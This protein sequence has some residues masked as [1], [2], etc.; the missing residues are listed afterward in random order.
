MVRGL[1]AELAH[2]T[3]TNAGWEA[4][5]SPFGD[6]LIDDATTPHAWWAAEYVTL[7]RNM[8]V[9]EQG[10]D[11][12]LMSALSPSWLT[13]G[14]RI[15]VRA[16]PTTR[17]RVSFTLRALAGGAVLTWTS[18]LAA[19]TRLRWPVPYA[20]RGV[21]APG[22]GFGGRVITLP[23]RSG[24]I[25]VRWSLTGDGPTYARA[26]DRL[27]SAY[28]HSPNGATARAARRSGLAAA[29][30]TGAPSDLDRYVPPQLAPAG[31]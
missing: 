25:V 20:A 24:R 5:T 17:G 14:R 15:A 28:L 1:Y 26:F 10:A 4:A 18:R 23:G 6:R 12:Y 19:G 7:V 31:R 16:A 29:R 2:T 8:L 9:R 21:R 27:M 22:L 30:R 11:V 13:P 3:G